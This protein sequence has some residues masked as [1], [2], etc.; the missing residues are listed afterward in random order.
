MERKPRKIRRIF[1]ASLILASL[2]SR[3]FVSPH[4][5]ASFR[6]ASFSRGPTNRGC[7]A[8]YTTFLTV[9]SRSPSGC[10]F[11]C[12][13][14]FESLLGDKRIRDETNSHCFLWG[15]DWLWF[16]RSTVTLFNETRPQWTNVYDCLL[17]RGWY[18]V[19]TAMS[20]LRIFV[21]EFEMHCPWN[22]WRHCFKNLQQ[23]AFDPHPLPLRRLLS[24]PYPWWHR[25]SLPHSQTYS[26]NS[27]PIQ[28]PQTPTSVDVQTSWPNCS[29]RHLGTQR[30]RMGMKWS[31][32]C[33][34]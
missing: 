8:V 19:L 26:W 24:S 27:P 34:L 16:G 33:F 15:R 4:S 18:L 21:A 30:G 6:L 1:R 29:W 11:R 7:F 2:P 32:R 25:L 12:P 22:T 5:L 31:L 23:H 14:D 28:N 20:V 13:S 3:L 10:A 17:P 9:K